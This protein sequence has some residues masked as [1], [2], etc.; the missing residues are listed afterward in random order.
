MAQPTNHLAEARQ[1]VGE[2]IR[3]YDRLKRLLNRTVDMKLM[4]GRLIEMVATL[5]STNLSLVMAVEQ[6]QARVEK[7]EKEKSLV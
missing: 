3:G 6:L 7:L 1:A 4:L 5:H 2:A